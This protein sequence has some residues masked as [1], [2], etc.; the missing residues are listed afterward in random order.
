M[1]TYT[2]TRGRL[3]RVAVVLVAI[4]VSAVVSGC[5]STGV[6]SAR[7]EGSIAPTFTR[8]YRWQQQLQGRAARGRLDTRA[9]CIRGVSG[10]HGAGPD[11]TCTIQYFESGPSTPVSF[12]YDVSVHPDGCWT[13]ENGPPSLGPLDLRTASGTTVPN[14]VYAV[15]G[16]F[17]TT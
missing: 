2:P 9:Q 7:L 3:A 5:A 10:D 16:C 14:P 11:W 4:T 6:T 12:T 13:A 15:D 1:S 17:R 8:M